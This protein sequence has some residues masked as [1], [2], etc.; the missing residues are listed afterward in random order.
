M[1]WNLHVWPQ[2]TA[3][4]WMH[5]E[6]LRTVHKLPLIYIQITFFLY[7]NWIHTF[8]R[9]SSCVNLELFPEDTFPLRRHLALRVSVHSFEVPVEVQ[10][11]ARTALQ[12]PA[13]IIW[14][15]QKLSHWNLQWGHHCVPAFGSLGTLAPP[16]PSCV[17]R[18]VANAAHQPAS[19]TRHAVEVQPLTS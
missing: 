6:I 19:T 16:P 14:R 3:M 2:C 10:P 5:G 8:F 1:R 13:T 4:F 17:E 9:A 7:F 15:P 11:P 18:N 12:Q